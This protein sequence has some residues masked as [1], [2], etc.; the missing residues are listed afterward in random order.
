MTQ[1]FVK[2]A[3]ILFM[4]G[5]KFKIKTISNK[6][7]NNAKFVLL[8]TIICQLAVLQIKSIFNLT[9]ELM[10]A[11]HNCIFMRVIG[12]NNIKLLLQLKCYK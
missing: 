11:T 5:Q 1:L 7:Q 6:I 9:A 8:L 10:T 2:S 3:G 4:L 12:L